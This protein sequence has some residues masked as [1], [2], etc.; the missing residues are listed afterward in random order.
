[1]ATYRVVVNS[2]T[3]ISNTARNMVAE[4]VVQN[5]K[6]NNV[7]ITKNKFF[8]TFVYQWSYKVS[9]KWYDGSSGTTDKLTASYTV[10]DG[11]DEVKIHVSIRTKSVKE[12]KKVDGKKKTV[13]V[14]PDWSAFAGNANSTDLLIKDPKPPAP[15][16]PTVSEQIVNGKS[17]IYAQVTG[18]NEPYAPEAT[19]ELYSATSWNGAIGSTPVKSSK[20]TISGGKATIECDGAK[21]TWYTARAKGEGNKGFDSDWSAWASYVE[22]QGVG[23]STTQTLAVPSTPTISV[24]EMGLTT[25]KITVRVD[26]YTDP[27]ARYIQFQFIRND[28]DGTASLFDP[29]AINTAT[30]S[31][32]VITEAFY[33]TNYKVRAMAIGADGTTSGWS[34]FSSNV[35]P[36]RELPAAPQTPTVTLDGLTLTARVDNYADAAKAYAMYFEYVAN[37]VTPVT[38]ENAPISS[39]SAETHI[40]ITPGF[41]YKVRAQAISATWGGGSWSGYSANIST[42]PAAPSTPSVTVNVRTLTA[43]VDGYTDIKANKIKFQL[44][45]DD[46]TTALREATV[47]IA[48]QS[49]ITTFSN[50]QM[51]LNARYKVRAQAYNEVNGQVIGS[52]T[53]SAFCN[54]VTTTPDTPPTP[55][56]NIDPEAMTFT[57]RVD[58]YVDSRANRIRFQIVQN[59]ITAVLTQLVTISHGTASVTLSNIKAGYN[60]K[61]RSQAENAAEGVWSA[62]SANINLPKKKPATPDVPKLTLGA[63]NKL[64]LTASVDN[65]NDTTV[66]QIFFQIIK[67]NN[68]VVFRSGWATIQTGTAAL[69]VSIDIGSEYKARAYAHGV[70]GISE[71]MDSDWSNYSEPIKTIP[72]DVKKI[73]KIAAISSTGIRIEWS[74]AKGADSYKIEY[75]YK[76]EGISVDDLFATGVDVTPVD[77]IKA[78]IYPALNLE[79]GKT[80][81]FRV[82]ASNDA[83]DSQNWSSIASCV[84]GTSPDAPTTYSDPPTVGIIGEPI[85]LNW[86]HNTQDSAEQTG[87]RVYI[88]IVNASGTVVRAESI[89]ATI[90]GKASTY[91]FATTGRSDGDVIYWRISTR[92]TKGIQNEWGTL[93]AAR[94]VTVYT[95]PTLTVTAGTPGEGDVPVVDTFPINIGLNAQPASQTAIAFYVSIIASAQ[96]DVSGE[97]G[98]EIHVS[99]GETIYQKFI[100]PSS[101]NVVLTLNPGDI[102]LVE[103]VVYMIRASVSMSNGLSAEATTQILP[104]WD[105]YTWYPDADIRLDDDSM[106]AMIRPFC[107]DEYG[108][109]ITVGFIL[110]VYRIDHDGGLTLIQ[111]KLDPAAKATVLD[112]HPSLDFARYRIVATDNTTGLVNYSDAIAPE[113][114]VKSIVIQWGGSWNPLEIKYELIEDV[115]NTYSGTILTLP[116]NVD[117]SDSVSPDVSMVEY[118]GRKHPVSYYGT[119]QSATGSWKAD[120]KKSDTETLRKIRALSVYPGDV[121]VREPS[122]VGYWAN[123]KVS[124][125]VTHNDKV[126]PVSFEITRVEGGA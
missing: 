76:H 34:S 28:D 51:D 62:Y 30:S 80:Y 95:R 112:L 23:A 14:K 111:E 61:A 11:A 15:S 9:G 93:S 39:G 118:I 78:L 63:T 55:T 104:K 71:G 40:T 88:K 102:Y 57:A 123:V 48:G 125:S 107:P 82:K 89:Y 97:D 42:D 38:I 84:I 64:Q 24:T 47:D 56:T 49:A 12:T 5:S 98:I 122:G 114:G 58:N 83:G 45:K 75:T 72:A 16:A 115:P 60:Y 26:N 79:M 108:H 53:W 33:D 3:R 4:W 10:A 120:I 124:Y 99:E 101:N 50:Y 29:I 77:G 2:L 74:A 106:T 65:Y 119:Q 105:A 81:Y 44:Y 18:Y 21:G 110:A 25:A 103:D 70:R 69:T 109:D 13:T 94:M 19:I 59:D 43:R 85:V 87:A 126:I 37:D 116:Y 68:P 46:G 92:G 6:G 86:V 54:N 90:E 73:N 20:V 121:Y 1:M 32:V 113:M 31:A 91:S 8:D 66:N 36:K 17:V 52:S 7:S 67:D 100:D 41:K 35:M 96:Y 22:C 117:V 27:K